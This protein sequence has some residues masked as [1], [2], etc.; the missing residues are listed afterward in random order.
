MGSTHG[1]S[2]AAISISSRSVR[3]CIVR[4]SSSILRL[5]A[6]ALDLDWQSNTCLASCSTDRLVYVCKLGQDK[7]VRIFKGH[8]VRNRNHK[9]V[10][11]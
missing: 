4:G 7:P 8:E 5:K 3:S 9:D 1:R 2:E 6:P 11:L 10:Y